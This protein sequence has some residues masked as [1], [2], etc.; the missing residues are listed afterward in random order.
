MFSA[1][2]TPNST[3]PDYV[4]GPCPQSVGDTSYPAMT[5]VELRA[6]VEFTPSGAGA[7]AGARSRHPGGVVASMVDG[8]THFFSNSI[9][10]T[11]WQ[12]MGTRAGGDPV[13]VP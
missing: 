12:S 11:T 1:A 7:Y 8:S 3:A 2:L 5:C 13:S 6:N 4:I 9:D 10:V